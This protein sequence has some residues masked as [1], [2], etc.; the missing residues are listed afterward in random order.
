MSPFAKLLWP[1]LL[2]C[3]E[4][5]MIL[6]LAVSKAYTFAVS[7]HLHGKNHAPAVFVDQPSTLGRAAIWY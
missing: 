6:F 3:T 4:V 7:Q 5:I 2:W 1:L